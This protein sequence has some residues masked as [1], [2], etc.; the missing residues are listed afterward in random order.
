MAKP[1][2]SDHP[3]NPRLLDANLERLN[4]LTPL[5]G[6]AAKRC[7]SL[8]E[9]V[10]GFHKQLDDV[11][12]RVWTA[13]N[14]SKNPTDGLTRDE[15]AAIILYTIEWDLEHPSLY[16]VLN[17]TLRL[18]D[19]RKLVPWFSY[20]NL[21][22][23]ALFKLPSIRGT[24]WRGVRGDLSSSYKL[25]DTL[26][27]W[28]FSSCTTSIG[29]LTNEQYLGQSGTCTLFAIQCVNGKAVREHSY[30]KEEDEILL[31][32]CTHLEVI[33]CLNRQDGLNI[34]HLVEV[35]PPHELL[36]PPFPQDKSK[37]TSYSFSGMSGTDRMGH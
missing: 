5:R 4:T 16:S 32:P 21:L 26:T 2:T 17:N 24:I 29:A 13:M 34:I 23:T 3:A 31:L 22:F 10:Q 35:P 28:G 9:A 19:R 6:Y 36:Q 1:S 12:S 18:E 8:T 11:N 7:H 15:S 14:R 25:G 33:G 27:W 37:M 30:F 20:L